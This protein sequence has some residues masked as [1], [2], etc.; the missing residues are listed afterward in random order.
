M[1]GKGSCNLLLFYECFNIISCYLFFLWVSP[2]QYHLMEEKRLI[3]CTWTQ[4]TLIGLSGIE[5]YD[6]LELEKYAFWGLNTEILTQIND[7]DGNQAICRCRF[8]HLCHPFY[9]CFS[10]EFCNRNLSQSCYFPSVKFSYEKNSTLKYF[11]NLIYIHYRWRLFVCLFVF[12]K[13]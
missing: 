10:T 11:F 1:L 13:Q 6:C 4:L 5:K 2:I 12:R 7:I 8:M 3:E 9:K